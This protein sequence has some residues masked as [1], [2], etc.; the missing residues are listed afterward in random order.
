MQVIFLTVRGPP[1]GWLTKP[2]VTGRSYN[3][4]CPQRMSCSTILFYGFPSKSNRRVTLLA[5]WRIGQN[6]RSKWEK[7]SPVQA[8]SVHQ[9]GDLD[10]V[11]N[12]R[13]GLLAGGMVDHHVIY[14]IRI[15]SEWCRQTADA[16][17]H[18][19]HHYQRHQ[20]PSRAV[21]AKGHILEFLGVFSSCSSSSFRP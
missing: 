8:M 10:E 21:R 19:G 13:L 14:H 20:A 1:D 11:T 7:V 5:A 15:L 9:C 16:P 12:F 18:L 4:P 3:T 2:L 17:S 6:R